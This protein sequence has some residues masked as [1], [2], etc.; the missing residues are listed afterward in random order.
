MRSY[1]GL[2]KCI[3][4]DDRC[5]HRMVHEKCIA[6]AEDLEALA[7]AEARNF[8]GPDVPLAVEKDYRAGFYGDG[9]IGAQ[10]VVRERDLDPAGEP[11]ECFNC[12]MAGEPGAIFP[13][14]IP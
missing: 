14:M 7:L 10:I 5:D 3:N 12:A 2:F 9:K 6:T 11:V 4:T 1:S 13:E 8:F